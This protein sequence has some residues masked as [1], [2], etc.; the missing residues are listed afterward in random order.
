[1]VVWVFCTPCWLV[2]LGG[3]CSVLAT[4]CLVLWTVLTIG[5]QHC[6]KYLLFPCLAWVY[7]VLG[8]CGFSHAEHGCIRF[9][10]CFCG[11]LGVL[12]TLLV[13]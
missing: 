12:Y 2:E 9:I 13:G 10:R 11:G 6:Y 3:C 7:E 4:G 5:S 1:M 8:V